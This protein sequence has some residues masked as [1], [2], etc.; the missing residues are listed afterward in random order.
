MKKIFLT[1]FLLL[2][3]FP[4]LGFVNFHRGGG[5]TDTNA[6]VT[7]PNDQAL[8]ELWSTLSQEI[9]S[10]PGEP[11]TS[12]LINRTSYPTNHLLKFINDR[13]LDTFYSNLKQLLQS[14]ESDAINSIKTNDKLEITISGREY[15]ITALY[16]EAI[17]AS[18][19]SA[20]TLVGQ[21]RYQ[22]R[23]LFESVT[24]SQ[25][26]STLDQELSVQSSLTI[27][28]LSL[29]A[30]SGLTGSAL[31][32]L[33]TLVD[34][35]ITSSQIQTA[36][37]SLKTEYDQK[38]IAFWNQ[39]K[40]IF[41]KYDNSLFD[42]KEFRQG[43]VIDFL[44]LHKQHSVDFSSLEQ[45]F[46]SWLGA[47]FKIDYLKNLDRLIEYRLQTRLD[48]FWEKLKSVLWNY[49][50]YPTDLVRIGD[51][52]YAIDQ[53]FDLIR[54]RNNEQ[55]DNKW[56]DLK[57]VLS[58]YSDLRDT[59][60]SFLKD[61]QNYFLDALW[62]KRESNQKGSQFTQEAREQL[63]KLVDN[64]I[65]V[66]FILDELNKLRPKTED[67]YDELEIQ[68]DSHIISTPSD[69]S[70]LTGEAKTQLQTLVYARVSPDDVKNDLTDVNTALLTTLWGQI[71]DEFQ[72]YK[73]TVFNERIVVLQA[74]STTSRG[75]FAI[76]HLLDQKDDDFADLLPEAIA[77]LQSL[78]NADVAN[79]EVGTA[80]TLRNTNALN[81]LWI[82]LKAALVDYDGF[83]F[84][85]VDVQVENNSYKLNLLITTVRD[86]DLDSTPGSDLSDTEGKDQLQKL[87]N[88][89]ITD[90]SKVRTAL[91]TANNGKLDDLWTALKTNIGL[92]NYAGF[93]PGDN[94]FLIKSNPYRI[95]LLITGVKNPTIASVAGHSLDA[96]I[97]VQLQA[98]VTG[99]VSASDVRLALDAQNNDRLE[100]FWII[101]KAN[102]NLGGYTGFNPGDNDFPIESNPYRIHLLIRNKEVTTPGH[103]LDAP[104]KAQL[105][106]LINASVTPFQVRNALDATNNA[107]L[108][109]LWS[110]L[111]TALADYAGHTFTSPIDISGSQ[112]TINLLI[113]N[114]GLA[115]AGS[116]LAVPIKA[117]LQTLVT[118]GVSASD[119]RSALNTVNAANPGK[120]D[121]L[122]IALKL[123]TN[124]GG[125]SGFNPVDTDITIDDISYKLHLLIASVRDSDLDSTVGSDLTDAQGKGQ[126]QALVNAG[127]A[128]SQVRSTLDTANNQKLDDLWT[129]ILALFDRREYDPETNV[130]IAKDK[131]YA[132][133][134]LPFLT[135]EQL[136]Q[137]D[138]GSTL[139]D[140][141]KKELQ[142]L[143]NDGITVQDI[144]TYWNSVEKQKANEQKQEEQ[145]NR[146]LAIGLGTAGGVV[147]LASVG[148]FAYW[149][150]KIR[151]S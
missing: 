151:K 111:K 140:D 142:A 5:L 13:R 119:V 77:Q 93:N 87:V 38:I 112:Y 102:T 55:L 44:T 128:A 61:N 70:K 2:F 3:A 66:R 97:K 67:K 40:D 104:I 71:Q 135:Q 76:N 86:S 25:I 18:D 134:I 72:D 101:L 94:D 29:G 143:V 4:I 137:K 35:K 36:F 28:Q 31:A 113:T 24:F 49:S 147:T 107:K 59:F 51:H 6:Q 20:S 122:W 81:A 78:L 118:G 79:D 39:L 121:A 115:T 63:Q 22:F 32:Q 89:G 148:G 9:A 95:Q 105:Q 57:L 146:D 92:G 73:G 30:G 34:Q 56:T 131:T 136:A 130:L 68:I 54:K 108:S 19:T 120:L 123:N 116:A 84:E 14:Y 64:S 37:S 15:K 47:L 133:K 41:K 43:M 45:R 103:S 127:V 83:N 138:S 82:S 98:L 91:D 141:A 114:K 53:L 17:K 125:Y 90:A 48:S 99:E 106:A 144:E 88:G 46:K 33:Q 150:L 60:T 75:D 96:P 62:A 109:M 8:D 10:Y 58:N 26:K 11:V 42:F 110:E 50:G 145:K 132:F 1:F 74:G 149:F 27:K 126:L 21:A 139:E 23:R 117:Q 52:S 16:E 124:L 129:E 7:D 80:L 12:I 100:I 85:N 69:G 65:P